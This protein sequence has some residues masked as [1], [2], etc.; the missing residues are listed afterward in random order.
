MSNDKPS[1]F[2]DHPWM[3]FFLGLAAVNGIVTIVR[4][5]EPRSLV[6]PPHGFVHEPLGFAPSPYACGTCER[7]TYR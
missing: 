6:P 1:F 5:H 4:G 7:G 2:S 3:T